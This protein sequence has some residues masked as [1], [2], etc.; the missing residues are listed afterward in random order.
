M[1]SILSGLIGGA[2]GALAVL[3]IALLIG[4]PPAGAL[5]AASEPLAGW[6]QAIFSVAAIWVA[7]RLVSL[8]SLQR[9]VATMEAF[10]GVS[11]A[12][13]R[14]LQQAMMRSEQHVLD[15]TALHTFPVRLFV[16]TRLLLDNTPTFELGSTQAASLVLDMKAAVLLMEG[17]TLRVDGD[18]NPVLAMAEIRALA[19]ESST[20]VATLTDYTE[21]RR[22]LA[23]RWLWPQQKP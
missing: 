18:G 1:K 7:A 13:D 8:E 3:G 16:E 10:R 11:L 14:L 12:V 15:G 9:D 20:R 2:F 22:D 4:W 17:Y 19:K 5:L 23:R 6:L 21:R